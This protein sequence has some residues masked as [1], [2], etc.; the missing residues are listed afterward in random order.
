MTVA[1]LVERERSRLRTVDIAATIGIAIVVTLALVGAGAWLLGG[2]RWIALP[3]F[4]PLV[5]WMLL[6]AANG[7]VLVWALRRLRGELARPSV[8]AAIEREQTLRAG[9]LRGVIEVSNSSAIARRADRALS[10]Q[11]ATR[12]PMLAPR[13]RRQSRNRAVQ[14]F[15]IA[16]VTLALLLWAAPSLNDGLLAI[17]RPIAAWRGTLLPS[18]EFRNLPPELLRGETIRI[19]I[20][21]PGRRKLH[22]RSRATG[23]GWRDA[24]MLVDSASGIATTT[25][26][27]VRGDL[28]LLASDGRSV[29]DSTIVHVTD[30]PFV[31]GVELRAVYPAYLGRAPEGLP[32]GEPA[33]VPQGTVIEVAGRASTQ[34]AAVFVRGERDSTA[35]QTNGHAF[36]GRLRPVTSGR[37]E[38]FAF[39][40]RGPIADV[41]LPIDI[42]VVPDSLPSVEL[43]SPSMDTVV[44]TGDRVPLQIT[45]TDDH[46][47]ATIEVLG[48]RESATGRRELPVAQRLA[49]G[50]GTLWNGTTSLDL[51]ARGLKAGE[52]L[53]VQIVV[54]DNSPWAQRGLSRELILR[55]PTMEERRAIAREAADSAANAAMQAAAEQKSLQQRTDE[56]SRERGQR[57]QANSGATGAEAARQREQREKE[58][59]F[60]SAEKARALA[61][62]QRELT[63]RV[64]KLKD[65][66][67][68]LEEQL[69]H[70]SA[71]DSS[72]ARQLREAQDLLRDAMT[73]EMMEQMQKLE[74]A[75]RDLSGDQARNALKDL[76]EMQKQM[77]EQLEKSAE[78]LKRAALEGAME[79]LKDEAQEIAD[80]QKSMADSAR[81]MSPESKKQNSEQLANRSERLSNDVKQLQDRLQKERADAAAQKAQSAQQ[82]AERS[83]QQM[84]QQDP[85]SASQQ[86]Q[87]AAKD[88]QDAR[89]QQV[90]EWKKELTEALDQSIQELL[91]MAR[92]ESALEEKARSQGRD[93]QKSDDLRGQQSAVKQGVDKAGERLQKEGQKSSLLSGRSQ[94]AMQE[95]KQKVSEAT[96]QMQQESRGNQQTASSL[97]DAAEALNRA[98][99][100]LARD[101]E[102]ANNASSATGFS[103]M[104]Q[105]LQEMA[106]KQGSIN[107]QAQ[108]LMPM[109]G[110]GQMS[111]DAQATARALARQ[112]RGIANQLEELGD[113]A[114]GDRA[115]ELAKEARQLAEA[116]EQTRVDANTVARQQQLFRRLLDAGRSLE[117]EEREDND[118]RE[119]KAATGDERFDPGAE[120]ARGRAAAKF[121]EPTWSDLRG[122]S[123]DER[124]AILEY[125]KRIN[126]TQP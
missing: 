89:D 49:S 34:L 76:S 22:L 35:F 98:A 81:Q 73:P 30:R 63:E 71:L 7:A 67:K 16:L 125:F 83:E 2:S 37:Y 50:Q 114:G 92:E 31:G 55:V 97:G 103:E 24:V 88:L 62:E 23:E 32:V 110:Q 65:A 113:A 112:Q 96:Q 47:L 17:R 36:Q 108:G 43:V 111:P 39:A 29:T 84:R 46:G 95:A 11:L 118:K 41:P 107:A 85:N 40:P 94:R 8:A 33:R 77:R 15:G 86:M 45:A 3:R 10:V 120:A 119:A 105:Q 57:N 75:A 68:E 54:V 66:A 102:R 21:A 101:R 26:G 38:W 25:I 104:M 58:M 59:S 20:S 44:A 121:R 99:A 91:Q 61:Q 115:G 4:M 19:S 60:E 82:K 72:L 5:V 74:N 100:S 123:A 87:Q 64:D 126:A 122:L 116:L 106:Q 56:A 117:K 18:L 48:T 79:T 70:A 109:P 13:M 124:R 27:P 1:Q 80:K 51:G 52:A 6:V 69:K 93:Q 9:A 53:R 42:D 78:M 28:V 12:G 14:S 90:G